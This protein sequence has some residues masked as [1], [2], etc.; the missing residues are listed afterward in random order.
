[1]S[2]G[3]ELQRI[4]ASTGKP[5]DP[6]VKV[7]IKKA[8]LSISEFE[9]EPTGTVA[10]LSVNGNDVFA[11][12]TWATKKEPTLS[13]WIEPAFFPEKDLKALAHSFQASR[14]QVEF[15]REPSTRE[16]HSTIFAEAGAGKPQWKIRLENGTVSDLG[17]ELT[18]AAARVVSSDPSTKQ[19]LFF[20]VPPSVEMRNALESTLRSGDGGVTVA[21]DRESAQYELVGRFDAATDKV[22][23]G[24][25]L[26]SEF[27]RATNN[28][29]TAAANST[30]TLPAITDWTD[31]AKLESAV[32]QLKTLAMKLG[33]LR[34][35]A[36]DAFA[37]KSRRAR[38]SLSS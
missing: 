7:R 33:K 6:S 24:W 1:M 31:T 28:A 32:G 25:A 37:Y 29:K 8:G 12:V 19:R 36:A 2:D 14:S 15:I 13:L 20:D 34:C 21:A 17:G 35:L 27:Q 38:I 11:E 30:L 18:P 23:Y 5:T 26:R 10:T 4:D 3:D 22:E 16:P 9:V